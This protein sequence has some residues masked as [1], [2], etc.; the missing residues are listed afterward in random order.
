MAEATAEMPAAA[1]AAQATSHRVA[2]VA[3]EAPTPTVAAARMMRT[4]V[5]V[6]DDHPVNR[7]LLVRQLAKLGYAAEAAADGLEAIAMLS[8]GGFGAVITDCNMPEMDGYELA[9]NIRSREARNGSARIPIIACTAN[10]LAGESANCFAAGMDDYLAKPVSLEQLR[11]KVSHWL[12]LEG[13]AAPA[14]AGAPIEA[15][16][17][18]EIS[19]GDVAAER[20]VL[21]QFMR[22][23]AEDAA[24]LRIAIASRD[25]ETVFRFAHRIRG[26]ASA[27]GALRLGSACG[28][29]EAAGRRGDWPAIL[30]GMEDL[31]REIA[32]LQAHIAGLEA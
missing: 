29:I 12:P 19:G 3:T 6:V 17:L 13:R 31:E 25:A 14:S 18:A 24:S 21:G 1:N 8:V 30:G 16:A 26:A 15:E 10:A 7:M 4:L 2:D 11:Q 5:L 32:E 9:R 27:I 20:Q 23:G 28:H 22:Y